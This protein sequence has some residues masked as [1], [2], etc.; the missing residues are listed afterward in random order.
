MIDGFV[1]D[2]LPVHVEFGC[3]SIARLG[4]AV[5]S[6]GAK[7]ALV[8]TTPPQ[9]EQAQAIAESLGELCAGL[10]DQAVMHVPKETARAGVEEARRLGADCTVAIGGGSTT[11]LAKAIALETGL[12]IVAVPTTYAGSEMTPIWGITEDGVKRTG[13]DMGV[14][15]RAVI[16][17]P[18]LLVSLPGF[19]TG[20][21]GMNAVAHCVEA[22]YAENANPI[23]S[24]IAE[25][26]IAAMGRSLATAVREP[27]N[28]E[29]RSDTLYGAWLA[30]T[31]LGAVGM[32]LHHKLCPTLGGSF[33]LPHAEVHTIII[34]HA[35]AYNADAAP[36]AAGRV[37]RALG[38][39][40]AQ[41]AAG[42]LHDLNVAIG[43]KLKLSD[44]GM[45]E[46]DLDGA[47]ELAVRN[48][49]YNPKPVTKDGI[50]RLLGDAFFGRRPGN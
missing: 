36:D 3:G 41:A 49:Y 25:E 21:S 20:P 5:A 18:E 44:I 35:M 19:V 31:A 8:L 14:L 46:E 45:K 24:L 30:G 27:G 6:L 33:D 10:Y 43:A 7:K 12:P 48:P 34:P 39:D 17:D 50:R 42:A 47:A 37:A 29:A 40:G 2:A 15:P 9:R 11:G 22:L 13:R 26:G 1:Y 38:A 23:I 16:Y 32:A 28:L 4:D